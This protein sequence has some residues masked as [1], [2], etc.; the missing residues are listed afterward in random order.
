MHHPETNL[1][2]PA[3]RCFPEFKNLFL[4]RFQEKYPNGVKIKP[5]KRMLVYEYRAA[6]AGLNVCRVE[7]D[8][9]PDVRVLSGPVKKFAVVADACNQELDAYSRYLGR[10]PNAK[11]SL[12]AYALLP[13]ILAGAD[14]S[15]DAG[16]LGDW[17]RSKL[18]SDERILVSAEELIVYWEHESAER[19][20]K[21]ESVALAQVLER[22]GFGIEPD[23]R[24]GGPSLKMQGKIAI[25]RL[26][27]EAMATASRE[28]GAATILLHLAAVVAAADGVVSEEEESHL[29]QHLEQAMNLRES[30]RVRLRAHLSWLLSEPP[31]TV[32][33]KKRLE[34]LSPNLKHQVAEFA[35]SVAG[36]DGRID[37]AEISALQKIYSMMG[38]DPESVFSDIHSLAAAPAIDP[39]TV[40]LGQ[41][42]RVGRKL[43]SPPSD[44]VRPVAVKSF[45]LDMNK[46]REKMRDTAEVA[47][48]LSEIFVE[49]KTV[50]SDSLVSDE[51]KQD[52]ST[53]GLDGP[54]SQLINSLK[55]I[56]QMDRQEFELRCARL[57]L[58]PEGAFDALNEA[59]FELCGAALLIG[60]DP[61][62]IDVEILKEMYV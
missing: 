42:G 7:I 18:A 8:G 39:V 22:Q 35:V 62:E 59:A 16:E 46:V 25:F 26:G 3:L 9:L 36:A 27:K 15:T 1:R 44:K 38:L 19:L 52:V 43:P 13:A 47:S 5:N 54:H 24:F 37:P 12:Q 31:G 33:L 53:V 6:S 32:G 51:Q 45:E 49:E 17:V 2:T 61:I 30:E 34:G 55:E 60:E 29:E 11:G 40:A 28:Y 50:S 10:N 48:L 58:L 20:S 41:Q 21:K 23:A 56:S 4:L 14:D 57:E